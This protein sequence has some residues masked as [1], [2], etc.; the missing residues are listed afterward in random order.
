MEKKLINVSF[1]NNGTV[2]KNT[3]I[4]TWKDGSQNELIFSYKTLVAVDNVVSQNEWSRTTG[5]LLNELEPDHS[6]RVPHSVVLA[7]LQ[8]ILNN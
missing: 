7:E 5:K 4:L 8:K 3:V 2:N 6:A 1:I